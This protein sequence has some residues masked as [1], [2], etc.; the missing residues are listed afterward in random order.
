MGH[1]PSRTE[2]AYP[3]CSANWHSPAHISPA[4]YGRSVWSGRVWPCSQSARWSCQWDCRLLLLPL[5]PPPILRP[6]PVLT[7]P[8]PEACCQDASAV[9]RAGPPP[10]PRGYLDLI[11]NKKRSVRDMTR[12]FIFL[13]SFE[14]IYCTWCMTLFIG[15]IK[16]YILILF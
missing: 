4:Q 10:E 13:N 3:C 5:L 12:L 16:Y 15:N 14:S 11:N 7:H 6:S 9:D 2:V 8:L 1:C